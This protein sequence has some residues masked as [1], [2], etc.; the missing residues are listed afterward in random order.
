M[1]RPYKQL[2]LWALALA[3]A[4]PGSFAHAAIPAAERSAL[5]D[6]FAATG[7]SSD[8]IYSLNWNGP[9]GSEC[10]NDQSGAP[11]WF[12]VT[13][14]STN[15]HVIGIYLP[16]NNLNGTVPASLAAL[17]SLQT[18]NVSTNSLRGPIPSLSALTALQS[19]SLEENTLSGT[20]PPLGALVN[21]V[22]FDVSDN[23]LTGAI[24]ALTGLGKLQG[25]N[26]SINQLSGNLPALA[27]LTNLQVFDV[28]AN[29]LNGSIPA[30]AGLS[31]LQAFYAQGNQFA[32]AI[33]ALDGLGAL[34]FFNL[35]GN[36][37]TGSIPALTTLAALKNID[38]GA[39]QLSGT[40]PSLNGLSA[41]NAVDV[42]GN[43][44][45]GLLPGVPNPGALV[46]GAT[47]LCGNTFT[48][49]ASADWDRA[50]AVTPWYSACGLT[51]AAF[52]LDQHGLAGA[53][54]NS[55]TGGQGLLIDMYK[56]LSGAGKGYLAAG[57][58][59]F[60][61]TAAGGQ[62]WY[63]VQ[64]PANTGDAAV[65]LGIYAA[66]GGNFNATPKVTATQ[67][68]TAT[69]TFSD[70]TNGT[71]NFSF[72]DGR[73]GS[74]PLTRIDPNITCSSAGDTGSATQNYLLSG[75]WYDPVTSGQGFFFDV[76]PAINLMFAA[77]YTYAPNGASIG[78]GASQ[79]WY[80]IQDN[81]FAPGTISKNGLAI[82]E[83]TGGVFNS[84]KVSA[85]SP[86][87][88]AN[89]TINSCTSLTLAYNFTGGTNVGKTG[90][91][92]LSRVVSAPVG[93]TP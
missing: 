59:T 18:L 15:S 72:T 45:T 7:G 25:F 32:G 9:P 16:Q 53:W 69:L 24:P 50:T 57:W 29:L 22:G 31:S 73:T 2:L 43:Q 47:V 88:T 84:G 79:R 51:L 14:D 75:A 3:G 85:G 42:G 44:L 63:T 48:A 58:Y 12:G 39:N 82:Y 38:V 6:L 52:N 89:L 60:D 64:G 36:Q 71:L 41:L 10:G 70:C 90:T 54:Y 67:V 65:T 46:S 77:W 56:D 92:N 74:I 28:H 76:N 83:T 40:L 11:A 13:C 5:L 17:T 23:Q 81:A 66:T 30:L 49:T 55:A 61:V 68:G 35:H 21:L 33:P 34:Q 78:G 80:T 19:V 62:R 86:V 91:I 27:G 8:W 4:V 93:C 26:G 37:L 87:G 1:A 20:I